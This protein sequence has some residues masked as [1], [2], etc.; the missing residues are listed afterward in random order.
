MFEK[1]LPTGALFNEEDLND[2]RNLDY[3]KIAMSFGAFIPDEGDVLARKPIILNQYRSS[4]CTCHA[5]AGGVYQV[6]GKEISPRYAYKRI[7]TDA[8]YPS[9]SLPYGAYMLD[10]LKLKIK[11]GVASYA[12]CVS[13]VVNSDEE[14][15]DFEIT[16]EM[17]E[18]A[19]KNA[20][21][22]YVY[23]TT[24]KGSTD[25][26]DATVK[27]MWEQK[28]PVL[29]GVMWK[30]KWDGY[31]QT[32]KT[33]IFPL[34]FVEGSGTGHAIYAVAWK[35][36]NNEPYIGCV[37][38]WGEN[39]GDKGMVWF[40]RNYTQL[41]SPLA[42]IPPIKQE[43]LKIEKEVDVEVSNKNSFKERANAQELMALIEKKF[44]LNVDIQA[45]TNNMAAVA[46]YEREKLMIIKAVSY[47]GW[48]FTD[49]INYL[50]AHSRGKTEAEAYNLNFKI[51][52]KDFFAK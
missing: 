17:R 26:F 9:S 33:G 52:R 43:E 11:E 29:I 4:S 48:K 25:I 2:P 36:I 22:S 51:Y 40:P 14:Y 45:R 30:Q 47:L 31:S 15:L 10:P 42:Y 5:T 23:T 21:G 20:G 24:S 39:W 8:K 44:P 28:R 1:E 34:R 13:P 3:S 32:R 50:Y 49:V 7:K 16:K 27:Y 41:Y 12:D 46:L 6:E 19:K 18:S 35:N 37:N 38:S